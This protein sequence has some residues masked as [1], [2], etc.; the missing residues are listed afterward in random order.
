MEP[1]A[2]ALK[3]VA[4]IYE[5]VEQPSA[6]IEVLA[7]L[8][9]SLKGPATINIYEP[10]RN[11][12]KVLSGTGLDPEALKSYDNHY[13]EVNFY[14]ERA[15]PQMHTGWVVSS[16]Q[17]CTD[18][19]VRKTEYYDGFL[20][21]FDIFHMLGSV[22]SQSPS[23]IAFLTSYR[24]YKRGPFEAHEHKLMELLMPHLQR[25]VRLDQQFSVLRGKAKALD[26][27]TIGVVATTGSC[28]AF[29]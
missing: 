19:E 9:K 16:D 8:E 22:I 29:S 25:A 1:V 4:L 23:L 14:I 27:L 6:W 3:L 15:R 20:R 26:A 2:E 18:T 5:A 13:G 11:R 12:G 10:T 21:P 24:S 28:P 7:R 17:L